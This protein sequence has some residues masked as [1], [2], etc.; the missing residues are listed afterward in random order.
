MCVMSKILRRSLAL[1]SESL[2][3]ILGRLPADEFAPSRIVERVGHRK[4]VLVGAP[5]LIDQ[6][7]V[8]GAERADLFERLRE[9]VRRLERGYQPF[10]SDREGE[11]VDDLAIGRRL[12]AHAST[13]FVVRE[14]GRY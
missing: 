10:F 7:R 9:R 5:R 3:S 12:E 14:D 4:D 1:S 6:H 2:R 11:R 8:V 13:L